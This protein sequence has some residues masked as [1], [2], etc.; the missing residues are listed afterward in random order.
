[1]LFT[2]KNYSIIE[3]G[4]EYQ[5]FYFEHNKFGMSVDE[6]SLMFAGLDR[7]FKEVRVGNT[8]LGIFMCI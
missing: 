5:K 2:V 3:S 1:M 4:A 7:V 8:N 6:S